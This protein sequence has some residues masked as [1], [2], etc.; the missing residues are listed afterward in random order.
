M[1]NSAINLRHFLLLVATGFAA[2]LSSQ[3]IT[4]GE[5]TVVLSMANY[6]DLL[7]RIDSL[8]SRVPATSQT[9]V[10]RKSTGIVPSEGGVFAAYDLVLLKPVYS[11]NTAFYVHDTVVGIDEGAILTEFTFGAEASHRLELGYLSPTSNM[12]WR[13][14]YWFFDADDSKQSG[15]DVDVKIGIAD[16]PDIAIDTVSA[17]SPDFYLAEARTALHVLDAE[18]I[19]KRQIYQNNVTLASGLRYASVEHGYFGQDIL[20]GVTENILRTQFNFRGLGPT[21]ALQSRRP[22]QGTGFGWNVGARTSLLFGNTDAV[23]ERITVA[24]SSDAIRQDNF[25][26]MLPVAELQLG[27]DYR[28]CVGSKRLELGTGFEAQG[29]FNGGTPLAGGQD[30]A[31]D[32]DRISSPFDEDL[33]FVGAYFR[34]SVTY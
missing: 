3:Q 27:L 20:T 11:N 4:Y 29:W 22:I 12:G 19:S 16:D 13:S 25:F 15:T 30:G 10:V 5:D 9:P 6:D 14:R 21:L 1:L 33:G 7:N 28:R 32:S 2:L 31:T 18:V 8:E 34:G 24:G 17:T 26:R 23:W